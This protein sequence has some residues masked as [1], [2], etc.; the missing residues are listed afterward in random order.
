MLPAC[1]K[2][3]R[4]FLPKAGENNSLLQIPHSSLPFCSAALQEY[5]RYRFR[6][7][8]FF[9]SLRSWGLNSRDHKQNYCCSLKKVFF[10][11]NIIPSSCF[12]KKKKR[13]KKCGCRTIQQLW[14]E[15][16]LL[17]KFCWCLAHSQQWCI[18]STL[19]VQ[20]LMN[21]MLLKSL[22]VKNLKPRF[23]EQSRKVGEDI[24]EKEKEYEMTEQ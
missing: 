22:N 3:K 8:G 24:W 20:S 9:L 14:E 21:A 7:V 12:K 2:K 16:F 1:D 10:W 6:V 15:D 13:E 23:S 11:H 4:Y 5:T 18:F 19:C 17:Y